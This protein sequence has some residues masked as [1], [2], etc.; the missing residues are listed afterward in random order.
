M[1]YDSRALLMARPLSHALA[2]LER[3]RSLHREPVNGGPE[4][5]LHWSLHFPAQQHER[6]RDR[7]T[8]IRKAHKTRRRLGLHEAGTGLAIASESSWFMRSLRGVVDL[9]RLPHVEPSLISDRFWTK[10]PK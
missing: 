8:S 1:T 5:I 6:W 3:H 10:L 2:W 7:G 9:R 4:A